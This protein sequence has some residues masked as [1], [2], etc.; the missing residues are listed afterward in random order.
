MKLQNEKVVTTRSKIDRLLLAQREK[1]EGFFRERE[2]VL[3]QKQSEEIKNIC[4]KHSEELLDMQ[5][6]YD[7]TMKD[8]SGRRLDRYKDIIGE[9]EEIIVLLKKENNDLRK[10]LK[11]Y[12][13]AY[14]TYRSYRDRLVDLGKEMGLTSQQLIM[15][16][17]RTHS[18]FDRMSQLAE[19]LDREGTKIDKK[20]EEKMSMDEP[21]MKEGVRLKLVEKEEAI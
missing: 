15:A 12:R 11:R 7:K 10:K 1:I 18:F 2:A 3:T 19:F 14:E 5:R 9:K 16:S 21:E 20:V 13:E 6:T 4:K 17:A 8:V